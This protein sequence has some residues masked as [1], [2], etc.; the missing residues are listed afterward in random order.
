MSIMQTKCSSSATTV[1]SA[2]LFPWILIF[3]S[4]MLILQYYPEWKTPFSNTFGYLI[5]KLFGGTHCLQEVLNKTAPLDKIYNNPSLLI[6]QFTTLHFDETLQKYSNDFQPRA[7]IPDQMNAFYNIIK[8]KEHV[9][10]W[11]WYIL[12]ASVVI[13]SSYTMIMNTPCTKSVDD[14]VTSHSIAMAETKPSE[15][16]KLYNITE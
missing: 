1:F 2:T 9:S 8:L 6:N 7:S 5:A 3:G 16:E 10:E 13:S 12:T 14:Y 11:I 15:P 4:M